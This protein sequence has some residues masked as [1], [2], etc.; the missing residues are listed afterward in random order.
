MSIF[1]PPQLQ[2]KLALIEIQQGRMAKLALWRSCL[3]IC[4]TLGLS[5][6][7]TLPKSQVKEQSQV[8]ING[9]KLVSNDTIY[10]ALDF[11]YP[12]FIWS[13]NGIDLAQ[14]I[15]S[16]PSIEA[17]KISKQII[18]PTINISLQE[19]TPVAIATSQGK[20]GFLNSQG[21]WIGQE[22]YTNADSNYPLP[23]LKVIDYKIEFAAAWRKLYQQVL[24]YPQLK[25]SEIHWHS[26]GGVFIETKIGQV[27]LGSKL[28]R[29]EQQFKIISQLK[30]LPNHLESSKIA[31]I[32]LSNP[33][34]NLIQ[35]Y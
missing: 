9:T 25:V 18:P 20:V 11:S 14:K 16:I 32:D 21:E 30:N 34:V 15:E 31:Y 4:C 28:S 26:S 6:A 1:P 8:R 33:G 3:I 23:K 7:V 13:I 35:R 24:L 5:L 2:Y 10:Q 27:F 19:K 12:Q 17:A 22:F 29:L